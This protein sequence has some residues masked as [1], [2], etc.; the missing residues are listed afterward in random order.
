VVEKTPGGDGLM[1]MGEVVRAQR[2]GLQAAR[3]RLRRADRAAAD[4]GRFSL[5]R[6]ARH[7][8]HRA[9][10]RVRSNVSRAFPNPAGGD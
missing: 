7:R 8:Q 9:H 3:R 10:R 1:G 5:R 2:N 6:A 4:E